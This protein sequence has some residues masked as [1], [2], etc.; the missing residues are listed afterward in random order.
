[1]PALFQNIFAP[2]RDLILLVFFAWIG[3]ILTEKRAS[4]HGIAEADLVNLITYGLIGFLVGGRLIFAAENLSAFLQSPISLISINTALSDNWAGLAVALITGFAYAQRRG[5]AL[6]PTL[7]A[8]TPYF[9]LIAV[10]LGFAHLASG[11][12]YGAPTNLPWGIQL[13]GANRYPTQF[14]EILAATLIFA[15]IWFPRWDSRPGTGFLL[16]ALSTALARL[17]IEAYRGDSTLILGGYRSAPGGKRNK[18]N[19]NGQSVSRLRPAAARPKK[20]SRA[21]NDKK[22]K[23]KKPAAP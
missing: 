13:W 8:L 5:L 1:M 22:R 16:F 14:F 11:L 23:S 12:A 21:P 3:A 6:W 9:A 17:F 4:R 7:D 15:L 10:G 19:K 20:T 18:A 2:P